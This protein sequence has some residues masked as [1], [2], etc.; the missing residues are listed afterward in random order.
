MSM[1][2]K[3]SAIYGEI[4]DQRTGH[5]APA[6]V[7]EVSK[8][9]ER[10]GYTPE[11]LDKAIEANALTAESALALIGQYGTSLT[12]MLEAV[13]K[14]MEAVLAQIH[15]DQQSPDSESKIPEVFKQLV[16]TA[17]DMA[18]ILER[19]SKIAQYSAKGLDD[20]TRLRVFVIG[21]EED[22]SGLKD[23]GENELRRMVRDAA[24]G[25]QDPEAI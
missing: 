1:R 11:R 14:H 15:I 17:D 16:M 12:K 6:L 23:K 19:V 8:M 2:G 21:G 18:R 9:S 4:T 5:G 22:D 25:F 20:L 24:A 7:E 10:A 13:Q 3:K